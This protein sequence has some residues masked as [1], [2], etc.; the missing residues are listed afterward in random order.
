G[1]GVGRRVGRPARF[2]HDASDRRALAR[3]PP[4]QHVLQGLRQVGADFAAQ[5]AGLEFNEAVLARFHELVV[6]ADLAEL[7]DN[8]GR[9]RKSG[10]AQPMAEDRRLA[11]AEENREKR[12]WDHVS[13][14]KDS[15]TAVRQ[16][17]T[18]VA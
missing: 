4:L 12:H 2:D 9:A 14:H 16:T 3:I 8:D 7:V 15:T 1:W 13:P 18:L 10:L 17:S 5:A 6:E 11:A